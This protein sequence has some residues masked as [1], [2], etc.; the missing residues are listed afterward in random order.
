MPDELHQDSQT[1]RPHPQP[2]SEPFL[3]YDLMSELEQLHHE[4]EWAGGHNAKTIAK[5]E[6][7][8]ILLTALKVGERIREHRTEG[9]ISIQTLRGHIRVRALERTFDLPAGRLLTL[10]QGAPHE[11]EA[12]EE[13]A[14]LL[15]IAWHGRHTSG[16]G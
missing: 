9:R 2:V 11:V 13:S 6:D 10:D 1:R 3:E 12:L 14:F 16:A 4:P 15:T 8:R 7:F 5:Y